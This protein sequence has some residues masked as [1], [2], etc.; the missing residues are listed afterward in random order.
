M[1]KSTSLGCAD[2]LRR[3]AGAALLVIAATFF[4]V[5]GTAASA[6]LPDAGAWFVDGTGAAL[7]IFNCSGLLCGRIVWLQHARDSAGRPASDNNNP[8]PAS[9][10]RPLCGLTVLRGLRPVGARSLEQRLALQSRRRADIPCLGQTPFV[11]CTPR[12][13]L[14]RHAA[15]WRDEDS[16]LGPAARLGRTLLA[17][18]VGRFGEVGGAARPRSP[19]VGPPAIGSFRS[20]P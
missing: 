10:R 4:A 14:C 8:D 3:A 19:H 15:V 11:R 16:A 2:R 1:R 20:Y 5:P 12:A 6:T 13:R 9:R 17:P 18:I 7:Q